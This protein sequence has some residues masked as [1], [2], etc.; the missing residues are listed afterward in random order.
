MN[1]KSLNTPLIL[2]KKR[3]MKG[4]ALFFKQFVQ[5]LNTADENLAQQLISPNAQFYISNST[6]VFEGPIGY[7]KIIEEIQ[8]HFHNVRWE[9][10]DITIVK[11]NYCLRFLINTMDNKSN[12]MYVTN[13]Y[14]LANNQIIE[15][16][17]NTLDILYQKGISSN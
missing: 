1:G 11:D 15:G 8:S 17:D 4:Y 9:I 2:H 16:Y 6:E 5:F 14:H 10:D 3:S 13:T 7:L 12:Q